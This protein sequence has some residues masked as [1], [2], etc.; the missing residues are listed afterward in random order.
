MCCS[1]FSQKYYTK[2][3]FFFTEGQTPDM[4]P[5]K[6]PTASPPDLQYCTACLYNK[7]FTGLFHH[8]VTIWCL[9]P[10]EL[11]NRH[12]SNQAVWLTDET[13]SRDPAKRWKQVKEEKC[14]RCSTNN[15]VMILITSNVSVGTMSFKRNKITH[16]CLIFAYFPLAVKYRG[17]SV[18][19]RGCTN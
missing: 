3:F 14:T 5:K 18:S 12:G 19:W 1:Q 11:K 9:L 16:G 8:A 15:H 6:P 13:I 7:M 17:K 4:A 10:S 2:P